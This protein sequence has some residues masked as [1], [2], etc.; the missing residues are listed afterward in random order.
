MNN[1]SG[2]NLLRVAMDRHRQGRHDEAEKLCREA[3]ELEP[4]SSDALCNLGNALLEQG[5]LEE[6]QARYRQA[7]EIRP[8]F[9]NAHW[10]LGLGLLL[11]GNLE[12]GWA[13]YEWRWRNPEP[14]LRRPDLPGARWRGEDLRGR[15]L[16]V[17]A[18]QGIGDVIQFCRYAGLLAARGARVVLLCQ[19][20]LKPLVERLEGVSR[21]VAEGDEIGPYHY[22]VPMLSVPG[23]FGTTLQTVP[24]AVPYLFADPGRLEPWRQ[25]ILSVRAGLRVGVVWA[26]SPDHESDGQRSCP[27][28]HLRGLADIPGAVFFS[29]QKG[30]A[31]RELGNRGGA[32]PFVDLAPELADFADTAAAIHHLD[33]VISVDTAVAHLAGAMAR[34][35]WTLL[36]FVPDWRWLLDREDS[37]WYPTMRLFRQPVA[38]DWSAVVERVRRQLLSSTASPAGG[39][40]VDPGPAA[41]PVDAPDAVPPVRHGSDGDDAPGPAVEDSEIAIGLAGDRVAV[42]FRGGAPGAAATDRAGSDLFRAAVEHHRHDRFEEAERLCRKVLQL[43]P[44]QAQVLHLLGLVIQRS[45]VAEGPGGPGRPVRGNGPPDFDAPRHSGNRL[46]EAAACYRRA[47]ELEPDRFQVLCNLGVI[48]HDQGLLQEAQRCYG[49]ALE[50]RPDYVEAHFNLGHLLCEQRRL[51]DAQRCY[52]RA[53]EHRPD[54]ARAHFNLGMTLLLGGD[55]EPG[56]AEYEWRWRNPDQK[57]RPLDLP[58]PLW[59]GEDPR[60]LTVLVWGEQGIGDV[61]Q[62]CRYVPL[63]AARGARVLLLC[64]RSLKSLL[65]RLEGVSQV[66]VEGDRPDRY[67]H[68][69][70]ILNVPGVFGTTLQTV[71]STVPYLNA[72]PGRLEPWRQ[73]IL[74][75]GAKFRVGIVWAGSPDH[76]NDRNRS[77][78]LEMFSRLAPVPG[79]AFF[80][81]QKGAAARELLTAPAGVP[82]VDLGPELAD[83]ADTAA[84]IHHRDLVIS[85]DTAVAHL[86][87]AMARPVWTLLPFVPDWR[88]LLDR[89]DSPWYPT[90][91]L[92]R[93]PAAGDWPTVLERVRRQ[94]LSSTGPGQRRDSLGLQDVTDHPPGSALQE[95]ALEHHRRG[96]LGEAERLYRQVLE[97]DHD[98]VRALYLLGTVIQQSWAAG[99]PDTPGGALATEQRLDEAL[100]CYRRVL[101][102]EPDHVE[103]RGNLG[104]ALQARGRPA[105]AEACYRRALELRP[106]YTEAHYN[107]GIALQVQGRQAEAAPCFRRALE[108]KPDYFEAWNNLGNVLRGLGQLAEAEQCYRRALEI[109]PDHIKAHNNLGIVLMERGGWQQ[110]VDCYRR[111]LELEPDYAEAHFNLGVVLKNQG[112]LAE[113]ELSYRRAVEIDPTHAE[114]HYGLGYVLLEQGQPAEAELSYRRAIEIDPAHSRAR[115]NLGIALMAQGRWHLAT[116]CFRRVLELAPEFAG[117]HWGLGI[118]HL[119]EGDLARGWVEYEWR[120]RN[121]DLSLHK[122]DLPGPLWKGEEL[123]GKTLLVWAEQGIGDVIQFCRYVPLLAARGATVVLLCQRSLSALLERLE[124]VSRVIVEGDDTGPYHYQIPM[125]SLPGLLETT[126]WTIPSTVPYLGAD[127]AR[128]ESW[129]RRILS[130]PGQLRVG[131]VWAG[132]P[133]HKNDRNRS[134]SLD[135]FSR[136]TAVPGLAFFSL[137]KGDAARQ[138]LERPGLVPFVDLGPELDDF[139]DTAAAIHH[140]DLV[141]SVDT[142]VAHLAGA[143]AR[144]V[145]TLVPFAPDWR[146]LLEREDSPWYPTMRLFRQPA[147]GD[148]ATVM[149]RVRHRLS[150]TVP[151]RVPGSAVI[152]EA[153]PAPPSGDHLLV[154]AMTHQRQ[155]RL[156]EAERLY[157]RALEVDP[158]RARTLYLLG[159]VI[160]QRRGNAAPTGA[161]ALRADDPLDEA[162]ACYRRVLELEPGHV[163]AHANLGV[164]LQARGRPVEAEACYRRALELRPDFVLAHANLGVVL[165]AQGRSA[166][167]E[168]CC[169]RALE[170]APDDT[171]AHYNLGVVVQT[172]MRPAEAEACYRRTLELEPGHAEAHGNLGVVLQDQGRLV[173]AEASHR[174]AVELMPGCGHAHYNLGVVVQAQRRLPEAEICYRRA[175]ELTPD[176]VGACNNLGNV[177]RDQGRLVEAERCY[178]RALEIDPLHCNAH[179]NLGLILL[180][181]GQWHSGVESCRRA[182]ELKPDFGSAHWNLGI[183]LL[184]GGDLEH[185]WEEYDWRW[186]NP[187][188]ALRKLDPPGP[189]W[190][191][192]DLRGQTLM[193]WTEQGIGDAIQFCRYLPILAAGRVEVIVVC[194]HPLRALLGRLEGVSQVVVEGEKTGPYHYHVPMLSL[195]RLMKTTLQTIPSAVPYLSAE[196]GRLERWRQR[197]LGVPG[198]IRVGVV[199]AGSPEHKN[200]R[201]RS[202]SLE[203][204]SRLATVPDAAFFSLQKGDAARQLLDLGDRAPFVDFGPDLDDFADTAA[205]VQH[206][207]LVISVDTAVAH[208]AGAMARPVWTLVPFAP[209]WRWLLD[210]EDSPWYPTML[211]FRQPSIGDWTTAIER[212]R[213]RL[214]SLVGAPALATAGAGGGAADRGRSSMAIG[215]W[216]GVA[217]PPSVSELFRTAA[218]LHVQGRVQE[219]ERL[220]RRVLE[221]KPDQAGARVNLGAALQAQ[222]RLIEAEACFREALDLGPD[223]TAGHF[224]LGFALQAQGRPREAEACY[225]RALQLAPTLVEAHR[226]LEV[227][228]REQGRIAEAVDCCRRVVELAPDA[229]AHANLG[230]ALHTQ[231]RAAEAEACCRRSLEIMPTHAE[232][233]NNLGLVLRSMGRLAEAEEAYRRA[234]QL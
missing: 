51:V 9:A 47:L 69:V 49:R 189:L 220:Y 125:M 53:L 187:D 200:D 76:K 48:L 13:E 50:L 180:E 131:V 7:L 161:R 140:L 64:H 12:E 155:G 60:G 74:S 75:V 121:H 46:A 196:P 59:K 226:N 184:L 128:L 174:R 185:G 232:A 212:V 225:R 24:A 67:H 43:D 120:W 144:Q 37:P 25:R 98:Q 160:Q 34:P 223:D 62:F 88:W 127:P 55:L 218:G 172:R 202:C 11:G 171:E 108:L 145:W 122:P 80:S 92:F 157:R 139:A 101:E 17:W 228:L 143:M 126:V 95:A 129:R 96:R 123:R 156:E 111:A 115:C 77:C 179:N 153:A 124:G 97:L 229:A 207:D 233:C 30:A 209:D 231:G 42:Q 164:A 182:L 116:D 194:K 29:L 86:A 104:V 45:Q 214:L 201:N 150:S 73:R 78:S 181:Q 169:R 44:D 134:C 221:L 158:D 100:R 224:N 183:M 149:E 94:L 10:N 20:P 142:A 106:D 148:W 28:E 136:L 147:I 54:F 113:A 58:G 68:H 213:Q 26:G 5:R 165:Q 105:E 1:R 4:R 63:L 173:E 91:R 188:L 211:L 93:Q 31:A 22:H 197:I 79:T 23:V 132:S 110:A 191:G 36:A 192:E 15:T 159:F 175:L 84:A 198:K 152:H 163:E 186:R 206:L 3:L 32:A 99:S 133:V 81:L 117:G 176:H 89:E 190:R 109:R 204:F 19:P 177:I 234:L 18:E 167:A 16:L 114:S 83:F 33:L 102:L 8:E 203:L 56:W 119:L 66:V 2:D 199:W 166:E 219:A 151:A 57:L 35:V 90:M 210:R 107:L 6:A 217:Q 85:V 230:A 14:G 170:L 154:A 193:V 205:V 52:R 208:L 118:M 103:A 178:R 40:P 222:G 38:G 195:P 71:P 146:W 162:E 138:L 87:G 70:P 227:V 137:Q 21:V 141:I 168:A 39:H 112:R 130:V 27:L 65:R 216:T 72:D 82:F 61:V 215:P 135:L 41:D